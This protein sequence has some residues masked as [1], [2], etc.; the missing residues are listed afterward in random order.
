MDHHHAEWEMGLEWSEERRIKKVRNFNTRKSM[1]LHIL[2]QKCIAVTYMYMNKL[3][4]ELHTCK[5][6]IYMYTCVL[7]YYMY[8]ICVEHKYRMM[9][10]SIFLNTAH[11]LHIHVYMYL[12]RYH[13]N[14]SYPQLRCHQH[15]SIVLCVLWTESISALQHTVLITDTTE[16]FV[17]TTTTA[18]LYTFNTMYIVHVHVIHVQCT[19][20]CTYMYN[21]HCTCT[22][23]YS[24]N[25]L[26]TF[27]I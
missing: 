2:S 13:L 8:R 21:V 6:H 4:S 19:L 12:H 26:L 22:Y 27:S 9:R 11:I 14:A 20:S 24:I 1:C 16:T 25:I 23:M 15:V 5:L 7:D 18:V 10:A 3:L 17:Q